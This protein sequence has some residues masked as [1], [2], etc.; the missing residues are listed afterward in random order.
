MSDRD[1]VLDGLE[2]ELGALVRR[3]RRA[4]WERSADVVLGHIIEHGPV[5]AA[6][7]CRPLALDKAAVSRHVQHL[8]EAG[9]IDRSP[10]P[11]DGRATLLTATDRGRTH[12]GE[13]VNARRARLVDALADWP[14]GDLA[15]FV[16]ALKRYNADLS[17]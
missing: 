10:D 5:R 17:S 15:S 11:D 4:W 3:V 1:E 9:L 6:D 8:L 7:L 14:T 2:S 13:V 12:I 16:A